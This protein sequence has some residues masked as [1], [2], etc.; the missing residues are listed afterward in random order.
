MRSLTI[1]YITLFY[2]QLLKGHC[3]EYRKTRTRRP[4]ECFIACYYVQTIFESSFTVQ[5]VLNSSPVK[6]TSYCSLFFFCS[7]GKNQ[8]SDRETPR[9]YQHTRE[10]STVASQL[11]TYLLQILGTPRVWRKWFTLGS[12]QNTELDSQLEKL[13]LH[14]EKHQGIFVG[15]HCKGKHFNS[16]TFFSIIC[17]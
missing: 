13:N 14:Q 6:N 15:K 5:S 11:S 10:V 7:N 1:K 17:Y 8:S 16:Y 3:E 4:F 12:K 9:H 2:F